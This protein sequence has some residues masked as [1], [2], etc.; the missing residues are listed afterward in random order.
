MAN[1]FANK[2]RP[3]KLSDIVGQE[4]IVTIL[5]NSISS[6]NL[7]H[8]YLFQGAYGCG[9]STMAR[10]LAAMINCEKGMTVDP[11]GKCKHCKAIFDSKH[12][13]VQELDGASGG[14]IDEIRELK[15]TMYYAPISGARKK[16][17]IIEEFQCLS[18][19]AA[20]S[21]LRI[22][23]EPPRHVIFIFTTTE[24][25]KMKSTIISRCQNH[26]FE[27]IYWSKINERLHHICEKES[28]EA[29]DEAIRVCSFLA[30]GSIRDALQ[31][32]EKLYEYA[33]N[34][35][36]TEELA[37]TLFGVQDDNVYYKIFDCIIGKAGKPNLLEG[38][39]I[40]NKIFI[41]GKN[42][43]SFLQG[44]EEHLRQLLMV[45]LSPK[46]VDILSVTEEKK[47]RILE[48]AKRF[49]IKEVNMILNQLSE[50]Y[51]CLNYGLNIERLLDQWFINSVLY[52][53]LGRKAKE[54][55]IQN[56]KQ[57]R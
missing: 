24:F 35:K 5:K 6:N 38:F 55:K 42:I 53:H 1:I 50:I 45:N 22:I 4:P 23:E 41:E 47:K 46:A 40:I 18:S 3:K 56:G 27:K 54:G 25:N 57:S 52:C 39:R 33:E 28:I 20:E 31:N 30:N 29:E 43:K 44:L 16:I 37:R 10:I 49:D 17:Y 9:K 19:D 14:K 34:K 7:H 21:L 48:E 32:L 36:I 12:S 8:A 26:L 15:K 51:R 11:C 13:D 2:Y